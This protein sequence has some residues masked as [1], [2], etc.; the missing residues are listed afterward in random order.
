MPFSNSIFTQLLELQALCM[1]QR[2]ESCML[3]QVC[4]LAMRYAQPRSHLLCCCVQERWPNHVILRSSLIYG[5]QSPQPVSRSLFLQFAY[6]ALTAR[7][8]TTFFIDEFRN[9]IF[10]CDIVSITQLLVA[11]S[12]DFAATAGRKYAR[13]HLKACAGTGML[14]HRLRSMQRSSLLHLLSSLA[15]PAA[16]AGRQ[17]WDRIQLRCRHENTFEPDNMSSKSSILGRG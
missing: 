11:R 15:Q 9:P 7:K 1:F 17:A 12:D 2:H 10:I 14:C 8:P 4:M 6:R 5:P 16:G 3:L 13:T